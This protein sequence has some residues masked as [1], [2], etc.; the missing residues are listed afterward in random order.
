M[1]AEVSAEE[2]VGKLADGCSGRLQ[3]QRRQ[4]KWRRWRVDRTIAAAEALEAAEA[5]VEKEVGR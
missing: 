1:M 5:E 2:V 4:R 3:W